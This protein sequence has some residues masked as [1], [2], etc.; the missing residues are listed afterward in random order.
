VRRFAHVVC[1]VALVSVACGG[2]S[3][4][5]PGVPAAP[6]PAP[7]PKVAILSVDGLRPDALQDERSPNVAGLARRGTRASVAQTVA[8][9]NTLPGHASM[10]SGFAPA[11]HGLTWDEYR[12]EKGLI[13]VA[14]IFEIARQAGRRT[15]M[16]VGKDKL[17]HL[18]LPGSLDAFVVASRGDDDVAN[19]VVVQVQAGFDL[20]FAHLPLTDLTGHVGGWMS[21]SYLRQVGET[22]R[23]V[24]R[25][26]TALPPE[27]VVIVTADH[28]G[29]GLDHGKGTAP[30]MAI[31]WIISGPGIVA[32]QVLPPS[33]RV[34]TMDTAATALKVLGLS[35]PLD[36]PGRPVSA[37]FLST[38][39]AAAGAAAN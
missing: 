23:A 31:P 30:D 36:A 39:P 27:T 17:R 20:L 15:A 38:G 10:L 4:S 18:V 26:L 21:D 7:S 22:D 1:A 35:L 16:V 28:G 29:Q 6:T 11:V 13:R 9:S 14:T 3:P 2:A 32:G 24:G 5:A 34:S 25:I 33:V 19:E 12:V 8:P 37:A